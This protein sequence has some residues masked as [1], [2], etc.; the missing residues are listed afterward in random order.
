MLLA[1]ARRCEHVGVSRVS[2]WRYGKPGKLPCVEVGGHLFVR[3]SDV[4]RLA[5]KRK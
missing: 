4:G 1:P 2:T 3:R 5:S